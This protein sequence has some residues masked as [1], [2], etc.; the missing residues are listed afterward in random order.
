MKGK[1]FCLVSWAASFA[2]ERTFFFWATHR[3]KIS[4]PSRGVFCKVGCTRKFTLKIMD[5][6]VDPKL[7]S[8]HPKI[9]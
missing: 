3:P 2:M 9:A 4:L 7:S 6:S 5:I 1:P 8:A